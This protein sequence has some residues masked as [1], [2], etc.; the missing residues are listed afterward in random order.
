MTSVFQRKSSF[1]FKLKLRKL[2]K[3]GAAPRMIGDWILGETL[4]LGGYSKV[5]LGNY[6]KKAFLMFVSHPFIVHFIFLYIHSLQNY[7]FV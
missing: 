6:P 2:N 5:K 3:G 1:N 4:G 7:T